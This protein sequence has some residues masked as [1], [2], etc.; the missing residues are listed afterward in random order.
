MVK[1]ATRERAWGQHSATT[2]RSELRGPRGV[3]R[4]LVVQCWTDGA[5]RRVRLRAQDAPARCAAP[6]RGHHAQGDPPPEFEERR[7]FLFVS[8]H[9][10]FKPRANENEKKTESTNEGKLEGTRNRSERTMQRQTRRKRKE[11]EK[12]TAKQKRN[13]NGNTIL[14]LTKP[15]AAARR[16]PRT[17]DRPPP[18][19]LTVRA[20]A[21]GAAADGRDFASKRNEQ[22]SIRGATALPGRPRLWASGPRW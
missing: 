19:S 12:R 21:C 15:T 11:N 1:L 7:F 8:F 5:V 10:C 22:I 20:G 14:F 3:R 6:H 18:P 16:G 17:A 9:F 4:N 2:I 13:K